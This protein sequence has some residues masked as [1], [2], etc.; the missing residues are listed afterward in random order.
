[1]KIVPVAEVKAHLS[2]YLEETSSRPVIITKNGR[3]VAALVAVTDDD[4]LERLLMAHSP[5]LR[6]L[7]DEAAARVRCDGGIPHDQFWAQVDAE[8][9]KREHAEK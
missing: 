1:M 6:Q 3:A 8:A 2:S 7:P 4:E 9:A 5:R